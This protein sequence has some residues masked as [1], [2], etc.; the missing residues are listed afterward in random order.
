MNGIN[1]NT[2]SY[3]LQQET[4]RTLHMFTQNESEIEKN[5]VRSTSIS[6]NLGNVF[7]YL[8]QADEKLTIQAP[9]IKKIDVTYY[10]QITKL[11]MFGEEPGSFCGLPDNCS[12][13]TEYMAELTENDCYMQRINNNKII[14]N[15]HEFH[16][17]FGIN[18]VSNT[19]SYSRECTSNN[20][21]NEFIMISWI[22][23][24][25]IGTEETLA[26]VKETSLKIRGYIKDAKVFT[27][28]DSMIFKTN[29]NS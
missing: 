22:K 21:K 15:Y 8:E 14:R 27:T 16:S 6:E 5:I 24:G 29:K 20:T 3:D 10:E 23:S 25:L 4:R 1:L 9:N 13:P 17:T 2:I 7:L 28:H 18:V 19:I 12:C 11:N 26:N